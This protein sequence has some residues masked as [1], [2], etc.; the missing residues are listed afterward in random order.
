MFDPI[1][2][3][4]AILSPWPVGPSLLALPD[5]VAEARARGMAEDILLETKA[6]AE[7]SPTEVLHGLLNE[8]TTEMREQ[9]EAFRKIRVDADKL[10]GGPADEAAIKL[11]KADIKSA[12]DALSLIVRTIEK[13]DSLQRSLADDRQRAAEQNFDQVAYDELLAGIERKIEAR[14]AELAERRRCRA[15]EGEIVGGS[16][17][18]PP[19]GDG[20]GNEPPSPAA[21]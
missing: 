11:A 12:S 19:M 4:P 20:R 10:L 3:D 13:I 7:P 18:G 8:M 16:G 5:P 6:V 14:A 21:L 17:A 9:F 1:D 2:F 15:D